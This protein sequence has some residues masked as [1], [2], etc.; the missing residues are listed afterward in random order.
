MHDAYKNGCSLK[1]FDEERAERVIKNF[2][3]KLE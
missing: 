2:V 1:K 3:K